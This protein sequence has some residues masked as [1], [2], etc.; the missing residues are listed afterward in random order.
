MVNRLRILIPI[1]V[2]LTIIPHGI[3]QTAPQLSL[4]LVG[5][6]TG[7]YVTPVGQTT[8]LKMQILNVAPADVYLLEG[9]AY[10][11]PNLNGTWEIVHSEGL[12]NF[13]LA[14][15]QS[16]IWTFGLTV[17]ARILAANATNGVPQVN[18]LVKII[19]LPAGGSQRSEQGAF[20]LDV[21]G[22]TVREQ[23][24]VI[25]LALGGVIVLASVVAA[26][27]ASKRRR[28]G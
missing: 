24:N 3:A 4:S 14:Y 10:L 26:Y 7:Q 19:Y 2:I 15:L 21:P 13:H 22:A 20:R 28:T 17:P 12:G 16:A 1:I 23:N 5:Q 6:S 18:L 25:W 9:D 11:D 27:P 8:E